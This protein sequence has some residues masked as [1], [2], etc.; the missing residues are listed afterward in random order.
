M[1]YE[2]RVEVMIRAVFDD[3]PY[4]GFSD[5]E[6]VELGDMGMIEKTVVVYF[7]DELGVVFRSGF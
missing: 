5:Y 1:N 4:A 2:V 6:F 7:A 3:E